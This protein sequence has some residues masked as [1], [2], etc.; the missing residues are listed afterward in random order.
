MRA[1]MLPAG[2]GERDRGRRETRPMSP[3][4]PPAVPGRGAAVAGRHGP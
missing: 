1:A 3:A 2:L 4:T